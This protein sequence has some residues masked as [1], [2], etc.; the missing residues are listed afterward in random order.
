L[1]E[2]GTSG[3]VVRR[4]FGTLSTALKI[5]A[6]PFLAIASWLLAC[7]I[8]LPWHRGEA[9][10]TVAGFWFAAYALLTL[11][12]PFVLCWLTSFD[13]TEAALTTLGLSLV[14]APVSL[15]CYFIARRLLS[16][17]S[18][19]LSDQPVAVAGESAGT[20]QP[21]RRVFSR[22]LVGRAVFA[23]LMS[24]AIYYAASFVIAL[25]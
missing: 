14:L 6:F 17:L 11:P 12:A 15:A 7:R 23:S 16:P 20:P 19:A 24:G 5:I 8:F 21:T 10:R 1:D 2:R 25:R 13:L 3:L 18:S 4:F 22:G 9:V